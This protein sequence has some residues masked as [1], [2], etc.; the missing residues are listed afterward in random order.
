MKLKLTTESVARGQH[1]C[2]SMVILLIA[3]LVIIGW[4]TRVV[5]AQGD[6]TLYG[7]GTYKSRAAVPPG[8]SYLWDDDF[9]T[10]LF[11]EIPTYKNISFVISQC[12]AGGFVNDL[13]FKNGKAWPYIAGNERSGLTISTSSRWDRLTH[14]LNGPYSYYVF[15]A[16]PWNKAVDIPTF[17]DFGDA[18]LEAAK[19]TR[20]ECVTYGLTQMH[21]QYHSNPTGMDA[22]TLSAQPGDD[23]RYAIIF[24]G[25]TDTKSQYENAS[26]IYSI[27]TTHYGYTDNDIALLWGN[28][29]DS[30]QIPVP[31]PIWCSS[32]NPYPTPF[33]W[34]K[35][36]LPAT[37]Q[38]LWNVLEDMGAPGGSYDK[39]GS[40]DRLFVYFVGHGGQNNS[41]I[42]IASTLENFDV[43]NQTGTTVDDFHLLVSGI[44]SSDIT[45]YYTGPKGWG[46]PTSVS[47]DSS[48]NQTEI[49]WNGSAN[50]QDWV[51]HGVHLKS[52]IH[53]TDY[54][55]WWTKGGNVL[56]TI[57]QVPAQ[58][59]P[60]A[61][62]NARAVILN[63][64][65]RL[66]TVPNIQWAIV[67]KQVGL[68]DLNW[69]YVP[70]GEWVSYPNE[71]VELEPIDPN[72]PTED[73]NK[74]F[75]DI[76][77]DMSAHGPLAGHTLLLRY[78]I[79]D[80]EAGDWEPYWRNVL[81][82]YVVPKSEAEIAAAFAFGSRMLSCPTYNDPAVNYTMVYHGT[83]DEL[84]YDPNRGWGYEVIYPVDS[85]YGGRGGYGVF[86]PFDDSPNN[87]N[88]LSDECPEELYDSF[89][90]AKSFLT[91][92][93]ESLAGDPTPCDPPEG[94]IFRV[95]VPNGLYRF[96]GAFGDADN[97]HAH[98][99]VAEDGGSGPPTQIGPNHVVLVHNFD[100]AQQTIGE[101]DA[102]E[103]GE[104]VYARVGFSDKIPPPGDGV[105]P[106]PQFVN[107]DEHGLA[108]DGFPNSP[109]L[110]V[111]QGY[112]R[113][114]QLQGNSNDGP[115]GP[116]DG[117]GGDIVILE[118]WKVEPE[119]VDPGTD[120]LVAHYAFEYDVLDQSGN[121]LHGK[122][123]GDPA[124]VDGVEGMA[125][126]FNGDDYVDCDS[127][128]EFSFTD[129][130]TV[131]T[132]VNIRS[133]TTAW[134][135]MIAKGENAWRLSVN[136]QTTG[137]HYA[138]TGGARGWQAANTAMELPFGEWY[139]VAATYDSNVGALVYINA[140]M[141][142]SNTDLGGIV[143][144]E[145]SLLLGENPEA[146]GRFFDG[147]LDEIK[148]YNRA[149]SEAEIRY[150]AGL[151]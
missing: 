99:I 78:E 61:G 67:K 139:H 38:D 132:W 113:I 75:V 144:N 136:N 87:R 134:M 112:I 117:N 42:T 82:C 85:P 58:W 3:V 77:F 8:T 28:G 20:Q 125:L 23:K 72:N 128:A 79:I 140:V 39:I 145:M 116:R 100:Q 44:H 30:W 18:H 131:S 104:G 66:V 130:M 90:G 138:F 88:K 115:G 81:A 68:N 35:I 118:L 120:G 98:R 97:V 2:R 105:F 46:N 91:D 141:D 142:A 15:F 129:A 86:G 54:E 151:R 148:I 27:L 137:I 17:Y 25:K 65:G 45:H 37:K 95:D 74:G 12:F 124:F 43:K 73:P 150:L 10:K 22:L 143:T 7:Q 19:A 9:A 114:H 41:N 101:A 16:Q 57:M 13:A 52:N 48:K 109:I 119:S 36:D 76:P 123:I 47:Y 4:G 6:V 135:A 26:K 149:L 62:N 59:Q 60:Q 121:G 53:P 110:E 71:W 108:T 111:T 84:A 40:D 102:V 146:T 133:V 89:V 14:G 83:P 49:T 29:T 107:M 51:H 93:S 127:N 122:V 70:E 69:D 92:C 5:Q 55:A 33:T 94:I 21:P 32:T 80:T 96:V 56:P 147:M 11:K 106:S 126:D 24:S 50:D 31:L 1:V 63:M 64:T 34:N 103:R